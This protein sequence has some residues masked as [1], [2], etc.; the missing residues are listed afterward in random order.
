MVA[1]ITDRG[2]EWR[3]WDLHIHSCYSVL[4]NNYTHNSEGKIDDE[5]VREFI[6]TLKENEISAIGLTNYFQFSDDDFNL[7]NKLEDAG[8][9]TFLNLEIRLS[10]IN[11]NDELFDYH[12][13]FDN[14]LD[15]K[16][17]KDL[18]ANLK[19][20]VGATKKILY[21]II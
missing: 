17:I 5:S 7:K 2:S 14:K 6:Q 19:A 16:I 3:K 8:I 4:N 18:L 15:N 20:N 1:S 13:I 11:K 9:A 10:N 12:I 21:S